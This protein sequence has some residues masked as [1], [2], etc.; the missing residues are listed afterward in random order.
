MKR[1]LSPLFGICLIA[2]WSLS[3]PAFA[4]PNSFFGNGF[5]GP[6]IPA[7]PV[8]RMDL[9]EEFFDLA[10]WSSG[11]FPGPWEDQPAL[12]GQSVR[13]MAANP[14]LFGA[15][16]MAVYTYGEEEMGTREMAIHFLDAGIYFGYQ[17]GGE[18]TQELRSRGREQRSRFSRYFR[19]LSRDLEKRLEEGC[20]RSRSGSIGNHSSLRTSFQEYRWEDFVLRLVARQDHSVSLYVSKKNHSP[21]S[22]VSKELLGLSR[23]DREELLSRNLASNARGDQ[24][25]EGLPVFTQGNTPFCG[26]HSLAMVAHYLGFRGPTETL[27]AAAEFNNTGSARGSDM[28]EVYRAVAEELGMKVSIAPRFNASRVQRSIESGLPVVVWRRVSRER[29]AVHTRNHRALQ[30]D[31]LLNLDP[32]SPKDLQNFPKRDV[33]GSP[34]HASV[35]TG[36]NLERSEVVFSEPWGPSSR[37]RRM[38]LEEME[39][40]GYA[41]FFF[42]F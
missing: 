32:P 11:T 2:T 6:I 41:F 19:D 14:T 12:S 28:I 26:I 10:N 18:S 5:I 16:P 35:I 31:P 4:V 36:I 33:K 38:R 39:A 25:I 13:R 20:G 15:V 22:L 30:D 7:T 29:E 40:T 27:A 24:L 1:S 9:T 34:S 42:R 21:D 23:R 8:F 3:G 17:A 37:Q